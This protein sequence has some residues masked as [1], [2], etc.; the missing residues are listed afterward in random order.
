[1]PSAIPR[2]VSSRGAAVTRDGSGLGIESSRCTPGLGRESERGALLHDFSS[3]WRGKMR[4]ENDDVGV[5]VL[6]AECAPGL[7]GHGLAGIE[8]VV[9]FGI[10]ALNRMMHQVAGDHGFLPL[11]RNPHDV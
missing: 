4:P 3:R 8:S 6:L 11:R 1:M 5:G 9:P 10:S 2:P 7:L